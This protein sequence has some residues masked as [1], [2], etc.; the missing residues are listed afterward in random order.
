MRIFLNL[1]LGFFKNY[2]NKYTP[3]YFI[4]FTTIVTIN[5]F[6]KKKNNSFKH[7]CNFHQNTIR[8]ELLNLNLYD[9]SIFSSLVKSFILCKVTQ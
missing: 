7:G 5:I 1:Y 3:D 6:L 9:N 2:Q 4:I 8:T